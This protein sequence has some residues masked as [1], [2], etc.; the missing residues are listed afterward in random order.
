MADVVLQLSDLHVQVGASEREAAARIEQAI[1]FIL[2]LDVHP[3]AVVLSGD[4]VDGVD[5]LEH[6]R[7]IELLEPLLHWGPPILPVVGNHDDR[8]LLRTGLGG[9]GN[10]VDL[11]HERHLQYVHAAGG[12][13]IVVLD[14][15]HTGHPGGKLCDTRHAWL[16]Q[17]LDADTDTPTLVFMHHPP[18]RVALPAFDAIGLRQDHAVRLRDLL[19]AHANVELVAS[20]HVHRAWSGRIGSIAVFGCPSVARPARPDLV[21]G[22]AIELVDGPVG[23]GLHVRGDDGTLV[24]HVRMLPAPPAIG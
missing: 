7:V 11:G 19:A 5:A 23:L 14:T 16:E 20:G 2:R 3:V 6:D 9:V 10:V 4:L 18:V 24:S 12:Q 13:R 21:A 15:Q 22:R 17:Q 1:E 8:G